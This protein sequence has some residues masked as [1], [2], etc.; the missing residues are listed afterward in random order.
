MSHRQK[1]ML[2]ILH[3]HGTITWQTELLSGARHV[4]LNIKEEGLVQ[5]LS[6]FTSTGRPVPPRSV[7]QRSIGLWAAE[8]RLYRWSRGCGAACHYTQLIWAQTSRVGC[9]LSFCPLLRVGQGSIQRNAMYFAC[10]YAPAGN[11][12]GQYP[13]I[14]GRRCSR[15]GRGESCLRGL[16]AGRVQRFFGGRRRRSAKLSAKEE[17]E[18]IVSERSLGM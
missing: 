3:R 10:F 9:S 16:C 18:G 15:C 8:K 1:V 5:N 6:Y 7:V 17:F 2:I 14:P 12:I 11:F 13:F 4:I